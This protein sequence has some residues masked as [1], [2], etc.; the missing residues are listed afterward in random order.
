MSTDKY[1]V[2]CREHFILEDIPGEIDFGEGKSRI[3]AQGEHYQILNMDK[4]YSRL[5]VN[6]YGKGRTIVMIVPTNAFPL[7]PSQDVQIVCLV[8]TNQSLL[9]L[10][11]NI[12]AKQFFLKV[13]IQTEKP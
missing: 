8:H 12:C 2:L 9:A 6:E 7:V 3:Y 4:K 13:A 10:W 1:N 11:K 5:V